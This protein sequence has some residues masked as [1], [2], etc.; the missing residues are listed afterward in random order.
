MNTPPE[1]RH[2][3]PRPSLPEPGYPMVTRVISDSIFP[4]DPPGSKDEP[5]VWMI[6]QSSIR[7]FRR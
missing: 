3:Q 2:Y 4:A 7:S 6:G 1:R 5:I